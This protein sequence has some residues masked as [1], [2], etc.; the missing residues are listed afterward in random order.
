MKNSTTQKLLISI[1]EFHYNYDTHHIWLLIYNINVQNRIHKI[2]TADGVYCV[3]FLSVLCVCARERERC[4]QLSVW[5]YYVSMSNHAF[6]TH[7]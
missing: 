5:K 3:I 7:T 2:L 1:V 4:F 6:S